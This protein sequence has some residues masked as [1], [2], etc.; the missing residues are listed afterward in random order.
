MGDKKITKASGKLGRIV[1][2]RL[3]PG[4]DILKSIEEVAREEGITSGII[5]GGAA[6]LTKVTLRNVKG[7]NSP[8]VFPITDQFRIFTSL[9]GPLELV[10]ISGTIGTKDD[11][12]LFAHVHIVVS[13]GCPESIAYGGH[14]VPGAIIYS[15][16][17]ILLAEVEE[18]EF[19][20]PFNEETRAHELA[21][22]AKG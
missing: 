1:A 20:R 13:S 22:T 14:L 5:L 17:E 10:S 3:A 11:G 12:Q 18:M 4:C 7:Y 15:T 21:P 16:G 9:E 2:M 19:R 8:E 6:S